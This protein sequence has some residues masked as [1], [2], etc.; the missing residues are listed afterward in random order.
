MYV[1]YGCSLIHPQ[2]PSWLRRHGAPLQPLRPEAGLVAAGDVGPVPGAGKVLRAPVHAGDLRRRHRRRQDDPLREHRRQRR[3]RGGLSGERGEIHIPSHSHERCLISNYSTV[4]PPVFRFTHEVLIR[5][6]CKP[7]QGYKSSTKKVPS[8][9]DS[10]SL[11][12]RLPGLSY[13]LDQLFFIGFARSYC[14]T[15]R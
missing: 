6:K 3:S 1:L 10:P 14:S 12:D 9:P 5:T 4:D 7:F 13:E 8:T 2:A 11:P 15:T